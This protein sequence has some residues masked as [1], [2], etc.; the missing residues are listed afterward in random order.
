MLLNSNFPY[1][2]AALG[3]DIQHVTVAHRESH[4]VGRDIRTGTPHED[5]PLTVCTA[6]AKWPGKRWFM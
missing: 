4:L 2:V 1:R 6:P 3:V 5:E